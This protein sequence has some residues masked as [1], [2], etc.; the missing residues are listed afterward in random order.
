[1]ARSHR[2]RLLGALAWL[3]GL[4]LIAS[5]IATQNLGDVIAAVAVAGWGI[6]LAGFAHLGT[7]SAD[8]LGWRALLRPPCRP[9]FGSL[10]LSRWIGMSVNSLLPVAQ[11]GGEF[12]RARL[13]ARAGVAGPVAGASVVV[14][15]T[16][17]LVSQIVFILVGI[18]LYLTERGQ[19]GW[20]LHLGAGLA[21]FCALVIGFGLAQRRG[22]F[23][24]L[25]RLLERATR[26]RGW[27]GLVGSAVALDREVMARYDDAPRLALCAGW[28]LLGWL[29]GSVEIWLAFWLLGH[30]VGAVE[31]VIL[32]SL[33]QAVRSAGFVLPGGLGAQEGAIVAGGL[34]LGIAPDLALTVALIKRARELAY[35]L[36]GLVAWSLGGIVRRRVRL[37]DG[38]DDVAS[39]DV[40]DAAVPPL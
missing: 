25:A 34:L 13:L 37:P 21:L 1:V 23:L 4:G 26:G 39:G 17:G 28:R 16:A 27:D 11:V 38:A 9:P 10:M 8:T 14:D 3:V 15:V 40:A 19:A 24:G 29:W 30:P 31:A 7:L 22:L 20:R 32:E 36:P 6:V 33:A 18:A 2:A 35:G 5:L 12:V